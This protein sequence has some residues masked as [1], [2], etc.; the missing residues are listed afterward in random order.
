MN[1]ATDRQLS[2]FDIIGLPKREKPAPP[3]SGGYDINARAY[4]YIATA[5]APGK[6]LWETTVA[7]AQRICSLPQSRGCGQESEDGDDEN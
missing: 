7:D 2:I 1:S 4:V 5:S 6:I 3:K